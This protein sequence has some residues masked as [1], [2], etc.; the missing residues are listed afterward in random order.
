MPR[1]LAGSRIRQR[2]MGL[3]LSQSALA[4][5]AGISA[6]YLNLI[7]HNKRRIAGR[8]LNAIARSLEIEVAELE[9]GLDS[10]LFEKLQNAA[11]NAP[12][13]NAELDQI[14]EFVGRT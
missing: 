10:P 4:M 12:R 14:G 13:A 11:A 2:R 3:G 1:S 7:E 6:S 8:T 9:E 5:Q